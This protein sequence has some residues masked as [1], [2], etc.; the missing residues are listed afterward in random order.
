MARIIGYVKVVAD[1]IFYVRN[2]KGDIHQLKAGDSISD[3]EVVY[4]AM[5][6]VKSAKIIIDMTADGVTDLTLAGNEALNFDTTLL[7]SVLTSSDAVVDQKSVLTTLNI[8]DTDLFGLKDNEV[9]DGQTVSGVFD[10][11]LGLIE[12]VKTKLNGDETASGYEIINGQ[13]VR[14]IFEDRTGLIKDVRTGLDF[15]H[16]DVNTPQSEI[17]VYRPT[18]FDTLVTE[19]AG[20]IFNIGSDFIVDEA[21]GTI[22]FTVT[23]TGSSDFAS[24]VAFSTVDGTAIAGSD[25]TASSGTLNFAAG[26]TTK[27]I[28]VA[29]SNDSIYE[30]AQD[31][32]VKISTPTN[33]TIGDANQIAT[34]VDDGRTLTGGGTANDDR[35][36]VTAVSSPSV[37]EGGDLQF[38]VTL[39]NAST[40]A[41][42][43]TLTPAS[44]SA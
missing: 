24:S 37:A 23:K 16:N 32:S 10:D 7:K 26:E 28:T 25:Y 6:N 15:A 42:T 36:V 38:T 12:D 27:Q 30:G 44:G 17:S 2:G 5:G 13:A 14:D 33:A 22:T 20:P 39:S 8:L 1:G 3:G 4:G 31:F 19:P 43:V 41:T 9:I 21:A 29:I 34:I 11:R 18:L 40:T 35:P